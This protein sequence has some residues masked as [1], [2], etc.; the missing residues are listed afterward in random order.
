[1]KAYGKD[2]EWVVDYGKQT[3]FFNGG[4]TEYHSDMFKAEYLAVWMVAI[5][6]YY[7]GTE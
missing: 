1:M 5:D 4:K 2:D 6:E 3:V 7:K